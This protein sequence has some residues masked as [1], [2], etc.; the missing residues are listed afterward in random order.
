MAK[1]FRLDS[2]KIEHCHFSLLKGNQDGKRLILSLLGMSESLDELAGAQSAKQLGS[3][4][5]STSTSSSSSSSSGGDVSGN[6]PQS[7]TSSPANA[8]EEDG[9]MTVFCLCKN[10][11]LIFFGGRGNQ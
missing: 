8:N 11:E 1:V 7:M 3:E 10:S 6:Q 9:D 5:N 2:S 4:S